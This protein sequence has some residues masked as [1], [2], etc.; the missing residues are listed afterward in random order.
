MFIYVMQYVLFI[1]KLGLF[2]QL[3]RLDS[4]NSEAR[5]HCVRIPVFANNDCWVLVVDINWVWVCCMPRCVIPIFVH[6]HNIP[7]IISR[8]MLE[9][10]TS[11]FRVDAVVHDHDQVSK[12]SRP[13]LRNSTCEFTG[14]SACQ[15]GLWSR[16]VTSPWQRQCFIIRCFQYLNVGSTLLFSTEM[17]RST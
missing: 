9:S 6:K 13:Y 3:Y 8:Y 2:V 15:L 4:Y 5:V 14:P 10:I 12:S 17:V 11:T 16:S 1:S 7:L